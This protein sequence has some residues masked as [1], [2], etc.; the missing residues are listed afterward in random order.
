MKAG[1]MFFALKGPNFN[2]NL[3]ASQAVHEGAVCAV[4]DEDVNGDDERILK[5]EDVLSSLQEIAHHHRMQFDIPVLGI[6]GSNGKTTNKELIAAVL[7]TKYNVLWTQGNLNNHIGV[8]L[9]LLQLDQ[10]HDIAVIEMGANH[11]GEIR[12][13]SR[14][15]DPDHALITS[16]GIAHLEGFGSLE[17]VKTAKRELY[18]YTIARKGKCFVNLAVE[19]VRDLY[20]GP[21]ELGIFYGNTAHPPSVESIEQKPMLSAQFRFEDETLEIHSKLIGAFQADNLLHVLA[22]GRHFEISAD[23]MVQAIEAYVPSN[24]RAELTKYRSN[25]V[26]LDAYNAN[27][28][29]MKAAI[30]AFVQTDQQ[31]KMAILGDMFEL[32]QSSVDYHQEIVDLADESDIDAVILV[33]KDFSQTRIPEHMYHFDTTAEAK[34]W[35]A[36][37]KVEGYHILIKGSRGVHLEVLL[38]D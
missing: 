29:S 3:F 5:V 6:T 36:D 27:P 19:H 18:D 33:G 11:I 14:I 30:H 26:I 9:T 31:P 12:A 38:E 20:D 17:G 4:V 25:S 13:L 23:A 7:S 1:Q 35:W 28:P 24:N 22:V 21:D 34:D 10:A 2:G 32:G 37:Q 15:A 8:P 16:I